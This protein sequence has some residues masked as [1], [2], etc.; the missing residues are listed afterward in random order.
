MTKRKRPPKPRPKLADFYEQV[1][2]VLADNSA[3]GFQ[4]YYVAICRPSPGYRRRVW[5]LVR[6]ISGE[7]LYSNTASDIAR[8]KAAELLLPLYYGVTLGDELRDT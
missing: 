6:V 7:H 1:V 4:R 3:T 8:A 2:T 5:E